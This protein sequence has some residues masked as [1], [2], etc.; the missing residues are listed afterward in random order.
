MAVFGGS[1]INILKVFS[2][3][4]SPTL[5][6]DLFV[7]PVTNEERDNLMKGTIISALLEDAPLLVLQILILRGTDQDDSSTLLAVFALSI[8]SQNFIF[9]F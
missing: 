9:L 4:L 1:S 5:F 8:S 6:G 3:R 2:S 7:M